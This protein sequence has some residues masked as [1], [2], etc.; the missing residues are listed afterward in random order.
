MKVRA[1]LLSKKP[2]ALWVR[3]PA[4]LQDRAAGTARVKL[5]ELPRDTW[6]DLYLSYVT[7]GRAAQE[8]AL[9]LVEER[10]AAEKI[11]LAE[12]RLAKGRDIDRRYRTL[13]RQANREIEEAERALLRACVVDHE[14]ETFAAEL[15]AEMT[16][17]ERRAFL[18][19]AGFSED[20]VEAGIA[21]GRA[22]EAFQAESWTDEEG[23]S[24]PGA[25]EHTARFYQRCQGPGTFSAALV[26]AIRRFQ[27][28][29]EV[30]PEILWKAAGAPESEGSG[31]LG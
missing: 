1:D 24:H 27:E 26:A 17:E 5:Q 28:L 13:I 15:P 2:R 8:T 4:N 21:T 19:E 30:T 29:E 31:P 9:L 14:P 23:K 11:P 6:E 22:V 16:E 12:E 25:S 18:D 10:A 3:V 7:A 20:A